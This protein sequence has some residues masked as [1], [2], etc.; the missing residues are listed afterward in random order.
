MPE[1]EAPEQVFLCYGHVMRIVQ[2]WEQALAL[3]WWRATRKNPSHPAGD[4]DT[5][6]SQREI[7]RLEAA[8]LRTTAQAMRETVS[9]LLKPEAAHNLP[10]LMAERNRLAHRFLRERAADGDA[11]VAGTHEELVAIGN[12]FVQS[13]GSIIE[14]IM[15]FEPYAGP[16][17]AHWPEVAQRLSDRLF[18]GEAIPKDPLQQ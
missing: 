14:T 12:R 8:F 3:V 9:P 7:R 15:S 5:P 11:F 4:F 2:M 10:S 16:V 13:A 17:P 18:S 1:P 6:K